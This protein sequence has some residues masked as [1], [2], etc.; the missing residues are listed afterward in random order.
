MC[1]FLHISSR[2]SRPSRASL[3]T[4]RPACRGVGH[5]YLLGKYGYL[6]CIARPEIRHVGYQV[7]FSSSSPWPHPSAF[8]FVLPVF[9]SAPP[10]LFSL[11]WCGVC[12]SPPT[13]GVSI[14]PG[15]TSSDRSLNI[16]RVDIGPEHG[17]PARDLSS[18]LSRKRGGSADLPLCLCLLSLLPLFLQPVRV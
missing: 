8:L 7:S 5:G 6:L 11:G 10:L 3:G 13:M 1:S 9:R 12:H 2:A 14:T 17:G 15:N 18:P 4:G 16:A